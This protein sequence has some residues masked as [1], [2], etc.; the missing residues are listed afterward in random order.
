MTAV[1]VARYLLADAVRSQRAV[2]PVVLQVAVLAVLFGGDPGRLPEP[3]GASVLTL[4]PVAAWLA[5][6][7][8]H[9]EDPVQRGVTVAAA[10]GFGPVA[11]GTLLVALAG[12]IGLAVLSVAWPLVATP[13][14]APPA[15]VVTGLL[16]HLA[17]GATGT[18]VGLLCARPWI[19]RIGRSLL[20][21]AVVVIATAVQPWLPPVGSAVHALERGAGP[22]AFVLPVVLAL[23]LAVL[24]AWAGVVRARRE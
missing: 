13:Y 6:T 7:V 24:V 15:V 20:V 17:A 23:G 21:G 5:L 3:W 22:G 8:A 1:A 2:L 11:A 16:A 14:S 4:Y 19:R 9:T 18:A 12:D 10:G